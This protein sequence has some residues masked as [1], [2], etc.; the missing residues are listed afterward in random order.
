MNNFIIFF[1]SFYYNIVEMGRIIAIDYGSKRIGLAI[2]DTVTR[3][4]MP[5]LVLPGQDDPE[6]DAQALV[7]KLA[8][9]GEKPGLFVVGLPRNMDETE[10]PQAQ[11]AR[12][13][14][15]HLAEKSKIAVKFQDERLSSFTAE[16]MFNTSLKSQMK[17]RPAKRIKPKKPLDAVAAAVILESFLQRT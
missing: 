2:G 5:W 7:K 16:T 15:K 10:G 13:F 1:H 17:G 3:I 12:T 9:E 8:A 11:L 6:K 14:G 4:A